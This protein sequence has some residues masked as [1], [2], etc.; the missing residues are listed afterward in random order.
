MHFQN[1]FRLTSGRES[2]LRPNR[3][4]EPIMSRTACLVLAF[5]F[6]LPLYA[7]TSIPLKSYGQELVDRVV[8]RNPSLLVIVMHVTP[9]NSSD[10]IIIASNIGRIG[11]LG[12]EDDM[13]VINTEKTNL[14]VAHG[15]KRFEVELV[16]HDVTGGNIGA[17]GL[18]FP[19]KAGDSKADLEKKA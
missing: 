13:R 9:P 18:V 17:L 7:Q 3:H 5:M 11:K 19:Y 8:A 2:T 6:G 14:E 1:R 15:G 10:N 16:L 12:D 4:R